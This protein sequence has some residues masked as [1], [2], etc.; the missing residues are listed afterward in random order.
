MVCRP[1][2]GWSSPGLFCVWVVVGVVSCGSVFY[3][4]WVFVV[5]ESVVGCVSGVV[6]FWG[7][8]TNGSKMA[9]RLTISTN[10][11]SVWAGF[12]DLVVWFSTTEASVFLL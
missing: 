9:R 2:P 8:S 6:L 5:L 7:F 10:G 3:V 12:T 1:G 11:V 4:V